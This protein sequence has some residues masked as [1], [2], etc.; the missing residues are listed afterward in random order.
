MPGGEA[1]AS[2]RPRI[3]VFSGPTA[4][5]QNSAPLVTSARARERYGLPPLCEQQRFDLLRPQRLAKPVVVYVE[6]F[7]AHPLERDA[8]ALYAPPDGWLDG[9][10]DFHE[11]RTSPGDVAVYRV[12]LRPEDGLYLLPYLARRADGGPW[13]AAADAPDADFSHTR[14][15]FYPDASRVF[16]E[17][18]RFGLDAGGRNNV[19]ARLA[20]FDFVRAA[21]SAGFTTTGNEMHGRDF[22]AYSP[23]HLARSPSLAT[24]AALTTTVQRTL[25][26]GRY[27]GAIWLEGSGHVEETVYWLNLLVDTRVPL[28]A[29]AAQRPHGTLSADGARNIVGSLIYLRSRVWAD[30]RGDDTVGAVMVQDERVFTAREVAKEDARPGG[31]VAS[32]G[33]GGV[34]AGI[35]ATDTPSLLFVPSSRHTFGSEVNLRR[36]PV[37][38]PGVTGSPDRPVAAIVRVKGEDGGLLPAA[39]P[40]VRITKHARYSPHTWDAQAASEVEINERVALNLA[41]FPLAGFVLEGSA[42]YGDGDWVRMAALR[43]A[44][45]CG[46]PVVRVGR[47]NIGGMVPPDPAGLFLGGSNLSA[48]KARLLLMAC[49]LRFGCP[50]P[51]R[52]PDHPTAAELHAIRDHL[53]AFQQVFATH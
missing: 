9:E 53:V 10:G 4:T 21:P 36:L 38:V 28:C 46:M 19:L 24:L 16:E 47:G 45:C 52:D 5:I 41:S 32:G 25:D 43:R 15:T 48:T 40:M 6:A 39:M 3:V 8:E 7:S 17:I 11:E 12:E 22:F 23:A 33:H 44:T 27:D 2:G 18:D 49:L 20:D 30:A 51:A 35:G 13:E 50:P 34:V 29:N 1:D 37:E 42:P 26:T 31:F 14:Q